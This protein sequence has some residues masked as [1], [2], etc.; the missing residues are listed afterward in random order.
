ML[1]SFFKRREATGLLQLDRVN[2]NSPIFIIFIMR[3]KLLYVK[4][5][6]QNNLSF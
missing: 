5:K 6:E 2:I 1:V 3:W 4:E